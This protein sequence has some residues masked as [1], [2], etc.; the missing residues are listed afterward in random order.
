MLTSLKFFF[1]NETGAISVD[2]VVLTAATAGLA[3]GAITL[4]LSVND[5]VGQ[6]IGDELKAAEVRELDFTTE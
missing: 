2:W 1:F 4:L 5:G 6:N 3:I